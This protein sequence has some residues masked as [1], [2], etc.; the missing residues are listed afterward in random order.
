VPGI[1]VFGVAKDVGGRDKPGHDERMI[2]KLR[3]NFTSRKRLPPSK[4]PEQKF[5]LVKNAF[6]IIFVDG[7]F[8][9]SFQR[10]FTNV[11]DRTGRMRAAPCVCLAGNAD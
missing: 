9:T 4:Y 5:P 6:F 3:H 11:F 1:H 8:T 7:I 10:P 2:F